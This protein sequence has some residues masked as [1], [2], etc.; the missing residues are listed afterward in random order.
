MLEIKEPAKLRLKLFGKEF[1]LVKPTRK[2]AN[3]ISEKLKTDEGKE[4][5]LDVVSDFLVEA[6]LPQDVAD[7][8]QIEHMQ[9]IF[10]HLVGAK[11]N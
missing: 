8:L 9:L 2:Q 5:A 11:K 10:E 6:G 1:Q 3:A 4:R 7:G